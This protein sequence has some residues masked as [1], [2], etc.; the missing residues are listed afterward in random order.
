MTTS[1]SITL[2]PYQEES[3]QEIDH[4]GGRA[5]LALSMGLGK[6]IIS[7]KWL[8]RHPLE[9]YPALV[10]C[11]ASIKYNWAYEAL[12]HLGIRA[13]ICEGQKPP[14]GGKGFHTKSKLTI[15]NRDILKFWVPHLRKMKFQT[16]VIDESQSF[17]NPRSQRTKAL[18]EIVQNVYHLVALSGTP[19]T[20]RP[21]EL[22]PILNMLWPEKYQSFWSFA[23]TYCSPKLTPWG[24]DYSGASNLDQLHNELKQTGMIRRRKE[25]VLKDLP[26]KVRRIVPCEMSDPDEY[27]QAK[28][29]FVN[30]LKKNMAHRVRSS[31]RAESLSKVGYLLRLVARLKMRKVVDWANSFLE[32]TDEKLILFCRHTKAID[33]LKRR[34]N[35]KSV[36]VNGSVTGRNRQAAIEQFVKDPKTRLFLGNIEAAGTGVDGLQ[37]VASE[38]GVVELPWTPGALN[39]LEDRAH[40]IGQV[41]TVFV[42][43]LIAGGTIEEKMCQV[44][45]RKQK[46][47]STVLDGGPNESDL[48]IHDELI[49]TFEGGLE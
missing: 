4:F 3:I 15:I 2:F 39:Q 40:R 44:L 12:H 18:K 27:Y 35:S 17:G 23:Q 1:G 37:R 43:F 5:L 47:I 20:N 16:I 21:S 26:E 42:N 31:T 25:D 8:E 22:W 45:Q 32:E 9:A 6:T 7:L 48:S 14:S 49:K 46:T 38:I 11:P 30:W 19:L 41:A 29:D 34:I 33:V 28:N 13:D 36:I 24:W 10:V